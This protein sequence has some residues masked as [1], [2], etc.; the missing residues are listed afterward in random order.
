MTDPQSK[1][2]SRPADIDASSAEPTPASL[3]GSTERVVGEFRLLRRLGRGG[4]AEVYLAE[5]TS[6][7][8]QVAIKILRPELLADDVHVKRFEREAKAAAGLRHANIVQVYL[9]GE[10]AGV[11]FIAQEFVQ[12]WNLRDYLDKKGSP[13]LPIVLHIMKQVASALAAAGEAGVVHRDIKPENIL[14]TRKGEVKVADFGLAQLGQSGDHAT[15]TQ[16]GMTMGTPLYMSP[17]QV[18][19]DKVDQRSDIYSF[20][21]TC[22]RMLAGHPPFRGETALAIA[23]QHLN[24]TPEPLIDLR[25]DLP[26]ILCQIVH[27]MMARNP[28]DRYPDA[29]AILN[30]LRRVSKMLKD[31]ADDTAEISLP[32]IAQASSGKSQPAKTRSINTRRLPSLPSI[33]F[34]NQSLKKQLAMF[35]VAALLIGSAS[36]ALGWWM[37]PGNP[38]AA[39][40]PQNGSPTPAESFEKRYFEAST[41]NDEED[42]WQAVVDYPNATTAQQ[43]IQLS[44]KERLAIIR[45]KKGD[46]PEAEALFTDLVT[47]SYQD[48]RLKAVGLAGLAILAALKEDYRES[49]RILEGELRSLQR[50]L[51]GELRGDLQET[52]RRMRDRLGNDATKN[53]ESYLRP[54]PDDGGNGDRFR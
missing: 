5:Q 51:N 41:R 48:E 31:P 40:R 4:M 54:I 12:G 29:Q 2:R 47:Y 19:G 14:V 43:R 22:Y 3:P 16:V 15:L 10:H 24:K 9:V 50:H 53:L 42:A 36:A 39:P 23:M 8:R 1:S 32:E 13:D 30:D 26:P 38:L 20:G 45:L 27:K 25:P 7:N 6:L 35:A 11:H 49:Q 33:A 46:F 52:V 28:D 37:R 44:A 21:V 18:S 34:L 17:E